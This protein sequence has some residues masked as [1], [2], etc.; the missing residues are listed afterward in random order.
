LTLTVLI[1]AALAATATSATNATSATSPTTATTA[2]AAAG[3]AVSATTA[4]ASLP[5]SVDEAESV[6]EGTHWRLMTRQG[7]VHVFRPRGYVGSSAGTLVYVH[8]YFTRSDEA[9]AAQH[10]F[11]QF[12]ASRQNAQFIVPEAPASRREPVF[13]KDLG[14]LLADASRL[15]MRR[16]PDGPVVALAHSGAYRTLAEWLGYRRLDEI[17]L[18]DG[19]Y[20]DEEAFASWLEPKNK[21]V[22]VSTLTVGRSELFLER[23]PLAASRTGVLR[24]YSANERASQLL[25]VRSDVDHMGLVTRGDVIPL[26]LRLTPFSRLP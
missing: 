14:Q 20:G 12:A 9:I 26:L 21:L 8:G 15:T 24:R 1:A 16:L 22:M 25:F 5:E 6:A 10:L 23:F 17:I 2:M 13:A 7:P 18:L 4:W 19:L 3:L 11:E